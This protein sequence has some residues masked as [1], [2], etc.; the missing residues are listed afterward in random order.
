MRTPGLEHGYKPKIRFSRSRFYAPNA[1]ILRQKKGMHNS[2]VLARS[3]ALALWKEYGEMLEAHWSRN[4]TAAR[5]HDG[6]NP[7]APLQRYD[8][9]GR[10]QADTIQAINA[11]EVS[12]LCSELRDP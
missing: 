12:P 10:R 5:F 2:E 8:I 11:Q 6:I 7:P 9:I 4:G 3:D 1:W